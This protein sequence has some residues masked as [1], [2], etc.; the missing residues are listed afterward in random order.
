MLQ[1]ATI[2]VAEKW[3]ITNAKGEFS[4]ALS[5]GTYNLVVTHSGYRK[6]EQEIIVHANEK[7]TISINLKRAGQMDEVV[8]LGSRSITGRSN[9]ATA[10]PVDCI[11]STELKQTG[12]QSLIQMLNFTAPSFNTS[13]QYL[14]D[15]VTLRGL[16]PT[17]ADLT[18]WH[19]LS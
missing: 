12:Q 1:N 13:R 4:M 14:T 3:T 15:P 16:S 18:E 9:L 7:Q 6:L 19:T 8:I 2:S 17:Y 11:T 10:V 5:P